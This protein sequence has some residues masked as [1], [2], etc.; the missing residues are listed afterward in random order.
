MNKVVLLFAALIVGLTTLA[1]PTTS[2][3]LAS[4]PKYTFDSTTGALTLNWGEFNKYDNW[5]YDVTNQRSEFHRRLL[6]VVL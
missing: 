5:D 6:S 3:T 4:T 2:G 1:M